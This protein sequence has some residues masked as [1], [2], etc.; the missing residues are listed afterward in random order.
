L[1]PLFLVAV[2]ITD[3]PNHRLDN[4]EQFDSAISGVEGTDCASGQKK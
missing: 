2:I 4:I 3:K 1:E